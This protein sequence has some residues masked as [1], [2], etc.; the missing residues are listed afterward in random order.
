MS[1]ARTMALALC[2]IAA[3]AAARTP[4]DL[5]SIS[6]ELRIG[7]DVF[8]SAL[9]AALP[10]GT[11]LARVEA[12]YLAHQGALLTLDLATPWLSLD[13]DDNARIDARVGLDSL[14]QLPDMVQD[15][16]AE[17]QI[18]IAP[19]AP[20]DLAELRQLRGSQRDL[21]AEA[22]DVR[23]RRRAAERE[24]ARLEAHDQEPERRDALRAEIEVLDKD[25]AAI[26]GEYEAL[27]ADITRVYA[28]AGGSDRSDAGAA[29]QQLSEAIGEA[30][31]SYG[32]TFRS[33]GSQQYLTVLVRRPEHKRVFVFKMEHVNDCRRGDGDAARLL[34]RSDQYDM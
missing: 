18:D 25:L 3:T 22:R 17:L 10:A 2:L 12:D 33:L 34:E 11:R 20:E 13:A 29:D 1:G 5:D 16:L 24:L 23:A 32:A 28:A 8:R 6:K 21:R 15:V 7:A 31:C 19:Y 27:D 9:T 30:V 4:D 14:D 26:D